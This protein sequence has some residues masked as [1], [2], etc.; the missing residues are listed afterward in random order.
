MGISAGVAAIESGNICNKTNRGNLL[1][2]FCK[3]NFTKKIS[4]LGFCGV[5]RMIEVLFQD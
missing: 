2:A 4:G 1:S 3:V 5:K